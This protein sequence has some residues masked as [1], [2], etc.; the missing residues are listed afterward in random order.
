MLRNDEGEPPRGFSEYV[1]LRRLG[2]STQKSSNVGDYMK[3]IIGGFCL[4]ITLTTDPR[5]FA[6]RPLIARNSVCS[7]REF[8]WINFEWLFTNRVLWIRCRHRGDLEDSKSWDLV[9]C[10]VHAGA[11]FDMINNAFV[12]LNSGFFV[13]CWRCT[14]TSAKKSKIHFPKYSFPKEKTKKCLTQ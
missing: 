10:E 4:G 9:W 11:R 12:K 14:K 8:S 3:Y 13:G 1:Q 6:L 5:R 7:L 2:P